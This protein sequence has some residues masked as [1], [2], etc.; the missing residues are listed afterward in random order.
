VTLPQ[1]PE[2]YELTQIVSQAKR[3]FKE[4]SSYVVAMLH[5]AVNIQ[6]KRD[7]YKIRAELR[8]AERVAREKCSSSPAFS[9][10]VLSPCGTGKCAFSEDQ[11]KQLKVVEFIEDSVEK[12]QGGPACSIRSV[13]SQLREQRRRASR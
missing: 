1:L 6:N 5:Q 8:E 7:N 13:V 10:K 3:A 4:D 11:Y 2:P 12:P 9:C